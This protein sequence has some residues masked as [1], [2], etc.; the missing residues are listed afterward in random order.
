MLSVPHVVLGAALGQ[1]VSEVPGA[2]LIAF[3]LGWAS[4]YLLDSL[5]HWE[6]LVGAHGPDF[7]TKTPVREW[8]KSYLIQAVLDVVIAALLIGYLIWRVPHGDQFWQNPVFWGAIGAVFPDLLDN[9]PFWN[10]RLSNL[11]FFKQ[12]R[13]L[14]YYFHITEA[15]Q[16]HLPK[17]TGLVT[18]VVVFIFSMWL[19]LS[20]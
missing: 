19:L 17:Y 9:I 12:Q 15:S 18:Q 11:P 13:F 6:R 7:D 5:P 10:R 4:H 8:P 20:S 14:H 1:A 16:Q 3:G 2:G